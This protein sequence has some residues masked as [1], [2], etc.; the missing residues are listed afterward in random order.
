MK[1]TCS[2]YPELS[3]AEFRELVLKAVQDLGYATASV[4]VEDDHSIVITAKIAS[5]PLENSVIISVFRGVKKVGL[6]SVRNLAYRLKEANA[7]EGIFISTS[8]FTKAALDYSSG[9]SIRLVFASELN[10]FDSGGRKGQLPD[11]EAVLPAP[12]IA[13]P[14]PREKPG[15][16]KIFELAFKSSKTLEDAKSHFDEKKAKKLFGFLGNEEHI[17]EVRGKFAPVARL[18]AAFENAFDEKSEKRFSMYVNLNSGSIYFMHF[19]SVFDSH[20]IQSSN[21]LVKLMRLPPESLRLLSEIH[22]VGEADP[23]KLSSENQSLVRAN[24]NYLLALRNLNFISTHPDSTKI[25]S[26]LMLP[27]FTGERYDLSRYFETATYVESELDADEMEFAPRDVMAVLSE[28]L[29]ATISFKGIVY[30]PY[31]YCKYVDSIGRGRF[32]FLLAPDYKK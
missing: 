12:E 18:E 19:G 1:N 20:T 30:M 9:R 7:A 10:G 14:A 11:P 21:E 15:D 25:F 4:K 23:E 5:K 6:N 13:P 28:I 29:H 27:K 8:G 2:D 32:D 3:A 16:H 17:V 26:N 31:F 24:P 22:M